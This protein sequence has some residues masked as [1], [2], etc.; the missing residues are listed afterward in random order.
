MKL[1]LRD[2]FWLVLV[3]ALA[4]CWWGAERKHQTAQRKAAEQLRDSDSAWEK[5]LMQLGAPTPPAPLSSSSIGATPS[6]QEVQEALQRFREKEPNV[7]PPAIDNETYAQYAD[8]KLQLLREPVLPPGHLLFLG[9]DD[10]LKKEP[11][12][13]APEKP[14]SAVIVFDHEGK[15]TALRVEGERQLAI[16]ESYFPAY[17][18]QPSSDEA[19]G[20]DA[21]YEVFIN[22]KHGQ[23][24]RVLVSSNSRFWSMGR[25]D[26]ELRGY[27]SDF[28][29]AMLKAKNPRA[30]E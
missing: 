27:F 26:F 9:D 6:P 22:L 10:P 18:T 1:N 30:R 8:R 21:K 3:A 7:Q 5:L 29:A 12:K 4:I 13:P 16:L 25:G 2:L 23:T 24:Y 28:V 19:G 15:T 17:R 14:L 20:W 11:E